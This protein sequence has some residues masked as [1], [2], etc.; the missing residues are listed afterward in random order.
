MLCLVDSAVSLA[1]VFPAD[2]AALVRYDVQRL[3]TDVHVALGLERPATPPMPLLPPPGANFHQ[4]KSLA[5]RAWLQGT[6]ALLHVQLVV[7]ERHH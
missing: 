3:A 4:S 2:I 7:F 5:A 1:E 6:T